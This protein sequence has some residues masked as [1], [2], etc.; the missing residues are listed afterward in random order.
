MLL[1]VAR[2]A[3]SR[4]RRPP[5]S[6]APSRAAAGGRR[7]G[8]VAWSLQTCVLLGSGAGPQGCTHDP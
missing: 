1:A 2:S 5:S 4:R 7:S 8:R 6:R 3:R